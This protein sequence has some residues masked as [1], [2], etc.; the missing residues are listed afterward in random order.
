MLSAN[1]SVSAAPQEETAGVRNLTAR[2]TWRYMEP[3]D[4]VV[5]LMKLGDRYDGVGRV[6][7]GARRYSMFFQAHEAPPRAELRRSE[8]FLYW[9]AAGGTWSVQERARADSPRGGFDPLDILEAVGGLGIRQGVGQARGDSGVDRIRL[10]DNP[11]DGRL[12]VWLDSRGQLLQVYSVPVQPTGVTSIERD[13]VTVV[14]SVTRPAVLA[15][16][17][18]HGAPVEIVIPRASAAP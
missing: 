16:F 4:A 5:G 6:D 2:F 3:S 8:Q 12:D 14:S 15:T 13:G 18:D 11:M 1:L 10:V 17:H 9:R 7:V